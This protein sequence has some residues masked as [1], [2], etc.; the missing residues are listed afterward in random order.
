MKVIED[1]LP[2]VPEDGALIRTVYAGICHSELQFM[3]DDFDLGDGEKFRYR[4]VFG[5]SCTL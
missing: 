2:K 5:K 1:T 4:D 3:D